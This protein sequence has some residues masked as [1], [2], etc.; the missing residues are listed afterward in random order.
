MDELPSI[1]PFQRRLGELAAQMAEP[2]FYTNP[3][4]AAD[5]TREHQK[6]L[7]LV[8]EHDLHTRQIGRAHV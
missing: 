8:A 3:R 1:A 6:L 7:Q 5:V 2:S 4:R